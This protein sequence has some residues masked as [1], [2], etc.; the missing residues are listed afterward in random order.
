[1][2]PKQ[3]KPDSDKGSG[4]EVKKDVSEFQV[5]EGMQ[6]SLSKHHETDL[7][8]EP[9]K[10]GADDRGP[11]I[12]IFGRRLTRF[13]MVLL[14]AVALFIFLTGTAF[15]LVK[16]KA[17]HAPFTKGLQ[18]VEP[19]TSI[20]RP[21]PVPDYRDMLD[22]LLVY[23]VEGQK[24]VTSMR[25]EIGYQSPT[26]YQY[27]KEQ[28]VAFRDT[29]YAFLLNQNLSGNSTKSWHSVLEKDLLDYL[30]VKLPQSS[31]DKITLTQ[32]ENL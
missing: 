11:A 18:K 15:L 24:M 30:R 19:V 5:P 12:A 14:L 10:S 32:V 3:E 27:F 26:R 29:V 16:L 9:V 1:M 6:E 17:L 20:M 28:S 7:E 21:V 13:R 4:S 25:V 22:F 31:P 23:D 8:N 2:K